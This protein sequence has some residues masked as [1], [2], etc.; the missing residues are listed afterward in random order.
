MGEPVLET[1]DGPFGTKESIGNH[2]LRNQLLLIKADNMVF[3][4]H[5]SLDVMFSLPNVVW[6]RLWK[7]VLDVLMFGLDIVVGFADYLPFWASFEPS[8]GG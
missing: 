2:C 1:N 8:L 4:A 3:I 6:R 7:T 5:T